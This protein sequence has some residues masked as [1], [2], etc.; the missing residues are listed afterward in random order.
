MGTI[1]NSLLMDELTE[2]SCCFGLPRIHSFLLV[3]R[4]DFF[5]ETLISQLR[6]FKLDYSHH[7]ALGVAHDSGLAIAERHATGV[8]SDS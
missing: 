7:Q 1:A 5:G 4:P 2:D 6:R 3:I 8:I